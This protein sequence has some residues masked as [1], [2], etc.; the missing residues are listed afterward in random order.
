MGGVA[1]Q[2]R[3]IMTERDLWWKIVGIAGLVALAF[4]TVYPPKEKLKYGID[5]YG[6]YSLTYE[7]D[8][9][10]LSPSERTGLSERVIKVL[11][12][13]IDPNQVFN[14]VWRPIGHNRLEI[15]M[16]R[17]SDQV[18]IN[19]E[20]Y[21][22]EQA[23]IAAT[24]VRRSEV[25]RAI[26]RSGADREAAINAL[27]RGIA[28]R[29]PLLNQA[30]A[31][32]DA[33]RTAQTEYDVRVE[34]LKLS[35]LTSAEV[36]AAL[37]K[38]AAERAAALAALVRG[39]PA[40]Q[41]LLD[42][43]A[44]TYD[45]LE[46]AKP[47]TQPTN[48]VAPAQD[49]LDAF[50]AKKS[51]H[52]SALA[53][54][55]AANTDPNN[56]K[57]G[58]T[59][60]TVVD[61]DEKLD[62]AVAAVL[63]TNFE[64][65]KLQPVLDAKP[66]DAKRK[67]TLAKIIAQFPSLESNINALVQASDNLKLK[68][69]G[70][71]RLEDPADLQRLLKGTG[72]L[73]FRILA[74]RGREDPTR[75]DGYVQWL[76][77]HGPRPKPGEDQYQWFEIEDPKD[78]L[79]IQD[80]QRDFD[81]AKMNL[82]GGVVVERYGDKYYV[83]SQIGDAYALVHKAGQE[84]WRLVNAR[85]DQ[86]ENGRQVMSFT[87]DERGGSR[88]YALTNGNL[89]RQL[90]IFLDDRC[91]SHANIESAIRTHG[92]IRGNFS[93]QE[94][95]EMSRKLNAGSLPKKLKDPPISVRSIGST[96][97]EENASNGLKA[98]LYGS[99]VVA[100][101]MLY[102]YS[103]TGAIAIFAVAINTLMVLAIMAVMGATLTLPGI[104]GLVLSIGMGVDT[105]VLINE[106]KREELEKGAILR[107]AIKL[108][109]E[110]AFSAIFDSHLTTL[111]TCTILYFL[112]SE[113]VKGFGLTLGIGVLVNLFTAYV[114]TRVYFEI[115]SMPR[116]PEEARRYPLMISIVVT[117][118]GAAFYALGLA[119]TDVEL[120]DQ[121]SL[122][123]LG[124]G[125]LICGPV[126]MFVLLTIWTARW[127][128]RASQKGDV[129]HLKMRRLFGVPRIDWCGKRKM[130]FTIS[131]VGAVL[132]AFLIARMP[133]EQLLDIE[134][135][136]GTSAQIDLKT[137]GSLSREDVVARLKTASGTLQKY[138]D[139]LM[140]A[141]VSGSGDTYRI[142][143]PGVPAGRLDPI[144]REAM[145]E[146]L[147]EISPV[148]FANP[149]AEELSIRTKAEVNLSE[150]AMRDRIA[151]MA[152]RMKSAADSIADAQVQTAGDEN[153]SFKIISRETS[154]DVV[155]SA[156]METM[157][158]QIDVQPALT[159]K[160][161]ES[162]AGPFFP[163]KSEKAAELGLPIPSTE[164]ATIDFQGW[165]GGVAIILDDLQP[166]QSV[167]SVKKRL[168]SMRFQPGFEQSGWRESEVIGL[169]SADPAAATYSR[170]LVLASDENFTLEA[171]AEPTPQWLGDFAEQEV[172]L[173]QTALERQTSL[174]EITQF[175]KQVSGEATLNAEI[176][177]VLS[178]LGIIIYLWFRFGDARWGL[179]AVV[180]LVHDILIVCLFI[181]IAHILAHS[182]I[183]KLL[184]LRE[185][186]IDLTMIAAFLTIVGYSV[187][188]T[189]IV[190]DRI[191]ENKGRSKDVTIRMVNDSI[192]QTLSRTFLT[193]LT[194]LATSLVMYIFGGEGIHGFNYAMTIGIITGTYSSFAI[195]GQLLLTR[196]ARE[197]YA[198]VPA[199]A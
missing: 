45:A 146:E 135:L 117:L 46:A 153:R 88:F 22:K 7:I 43:A 14:L 186:R 104:A 84:D 114:V 28:G 101:I 73:E 109:Y 119:V 98:A 76:K 54:V 34:A 128:H 151:K 154:K 194:T 29:E 56:L 21:E 126:M 100:A 91:V 171:G 155:V 83:L 42:D 38:P 74:E 90:A 47:T 53:A 58:V 67:E 183:G 93:R 108:G 120:R 125:L 196:K 127:I 49:A 142:Y 32:Y 12:D 176:A 184:M 121:S 65:A 168:R 25:L 82:P 68:R 40:R 165:R 57:D 20:A 18:R 160:V 115:M 174:S 167:D 80:L 4:A 16:P 193:S 24:H 166:P 134:F 173:T 189:I 190:Y 129:E 27:I 157:R 95:E 99:L 112:G 55:M 26:A 152:T 96:L 8:D 163:I 140:S 188:D 195:A 36:E 156:I 116:V 138:S 107:M 94:V 143:S 1:N 136:G 89:K 37:A 177:L 199:A 86:D 6:G 169:T 63:E 102:F 59:I 110:R 161:A 113:E 11:K 181:G 133:N 2:T 111:L 182:A 23:A 62:K 70:E 130:F 158:D 103:Y 122:I 64:I 148:T 198:A 44:R 192:N 41:A 75:F 179:A 144:V 19:R 30:A 10:G 39:V 147:S 81:A 123:G 77:D 15:Q 170:M 52:Q 85:P 92:Q 72:V 141:T 105:N 150:N 9:S 31:A 197:A 162:P 79:N 71:G 87:L 132:G 159:F 191:R 106:R 137:P 35:N 97:G 51:A 33:H 178:W 3:N 139:A 5:L 172:K 118:I 164:A 185:F 50:N 149:A 78:F 66:T 131:I 13:R 61:L 175:D 60:N 187:S 48:G 145:D 180:A 69:R 17:P 124:R